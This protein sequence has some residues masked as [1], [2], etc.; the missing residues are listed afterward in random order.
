MSKIRFWS[1]RKP[2]SSRIHAPTRITAQRP[3]FRFR[4]NGQRYGLTPRTTRPM[5]MAAAGVDDGAWREAVGMGGN[6]Q[7]HTSLPLREELTVG[8]ASRVG[9]PHRLQRPLRATVFIPGES[10]TTGRQ[11]PLVSIPPR[12]RLAG[13]LRRN[14]CGAVTCSGSVVYQLGWCFPKSMSSHIVAAR[15]QGFMLVAVPR[16]ARDFQDI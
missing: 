4:A 16:G 9:L 3:H 14:C 1:L 10:A 2:S 6:A 5:P 13:P 12:N 7:C 11:S 8:G 15:P